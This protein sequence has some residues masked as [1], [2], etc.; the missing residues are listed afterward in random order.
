MPAWQNFW[1]NNW[2][3]SATLITASDTMAMTMTDELVLTEGYGS[4]LPDALLTQTN[5]TGALSTIQED[6]DAP[7]ATW[8]TGTGAIVLRVSF[9]SPPSNLVSGNRQEFRLYVRPG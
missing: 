6:P 3:A 4:L 7:S 9:P 2:G 8:M 5:L 1:A